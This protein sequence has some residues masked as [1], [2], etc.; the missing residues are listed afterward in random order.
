MTSQFILTSC[1]FYLAAPWLLQAEPSALPAA[2]TAPVNSIPWSQL[3]VE[4]QKKYTGDGIAT[5]PTEYGAKLK[6]VM[7]DLEGDVTNEGLWLTSS[8]DEDAGKTA[9]F[10]VIAT[11]ISRRGSTNPVVHLPATGRARASNDGAAFIRPGL[12]EEYTVSMDGVRQDFVVLQKPAGEGELS[13]KLEVSGAKAEA[14]EYG[15]KLTVETTRRELAYS[16]LKVLDA[17]GKELTARIQ[18]DGINS[19]HVVIDDAEAIY[20]I[21]IDPT[22]SDADWVS[23]GDITGANGNV[24]ALTTDASG[25]LYVAGEFTAIVNILAN[26]IAKWDGSVWTALGTG[27]NGTVHALK[28]SGGIV[29]AGGEFTQAGG[30]SANKIARWDGSSWSALG[31]GIGGTSPYLGGPTVLGLEVSGSDLFACGTFTTAG[32]APVTNIARWDGSTWNSL[33][34]GTDSIVNT[35]IMFGS[36]L[37]AGGGFTTAGGVNAPYIA[38]WNGSTWSPVGGGVDRRV[39]AFAVSGV[40]PVCRGRLL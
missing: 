32:G 9:R 30:M 2:S 26:R 23:T 4:A 27:L 40:N 12:I 8:A 1:V 28:V 13:I 18:V 3:G 34:S 17:V 20:P 37:Y 11:E 15:V 19:L 39:F 21:R 25:N 7:Q 33:G 16:R 38:K 6:A 22:F 29:Y 24:N 10:R 36:E 14:A 35:I 31:T 5:L